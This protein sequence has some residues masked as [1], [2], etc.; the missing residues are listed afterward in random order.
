MAEYKTLD[1]LVQKFPNKTEREE[2][3]K[4]MSNEEIDVLINHMRNIQGKVY[5]KKFKK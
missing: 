2:Q 4:K 3:L 5:L 1:E